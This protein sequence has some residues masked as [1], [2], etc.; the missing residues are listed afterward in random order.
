MTMKYI[1]FLKTGEANVKPP[2]QN[3]TVDINKAVVDCYKF[4]VEG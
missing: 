4:P 1:Y 3:K 2:R